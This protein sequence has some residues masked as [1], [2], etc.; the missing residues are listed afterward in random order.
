M[1]CV[2]LS[3]GCLSSLSGQN[4]PSVVD[5]SAGVNAMF[6]EDNAPS[7]TGKTVSEWYVEHCNKVQHLTTGH[8]RS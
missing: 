5:L 2:Y 8:A 3:E 4:H 1:I 7:H 6:Q